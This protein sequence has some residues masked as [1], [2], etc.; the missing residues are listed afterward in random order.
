MEVRT[1]AKMSGVI[2]V[3]NVSRGVMTNMMVT[4]SRKMTGMPICKCTRNFDSAF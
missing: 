2:S 3:T 4:M 1:R